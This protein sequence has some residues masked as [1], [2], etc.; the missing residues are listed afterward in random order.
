MKIIQLAYAADFEGWRVSARDALLAGVEPGGIDWATDET[1]PSF[2][3]Q[4]DHGAEL[5]ANHIVDDLQD[6]GRTR[7]A[8]NNGS[9]P[10]AA[11]VPKAFIDLS[12]QLIAH[13]DSERF[14][15][16]YRL[17]WRLQHSSRLLQNAADTDVFKAAK[18]AKH[19]RRDRHKMK[20]FVRFRK[21]GETADGIEQFVSWFE[22]THN[23]V[24]ITAPFFAK[25]FANMLWSI[26]TP[27]ACA[28]WD[29]KEL[30]FTSGITSEAAPVTDDLED[31]WRTY[32]ASIFNP[33][34]LKVAAMKS[35]MPKKYW[36]N[37]PEADL[38]PE[39][40]K[41]ARSREAAMIQSAPTEPN[42]TMMRQLHRSMPR[43]RQP[44]DDISDLNELGAALNR[45]RKCAFASRSTQ[46]VCGEGPARADMMIVG[47]QPGDHEDLT[48]HSFVGPAGVLL[49]ELLGEAQLNRKA[50]Y[51]T[52]AVK[53][54]KYEARGK[55]R[56]HIN[57]S[58]AEIDHCRWW[59]MKE[60]ELV[61]P[62]VIV[63]L[64]ASALTSIC[65][66]KIRLAECRGDAIFLG[67]D[68]RLVASFHPSYVLRQSGAEAMAARRAIVTDLKL[69]AGLLH[70]RDTA[71]ERHRMAKQKVLV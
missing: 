1:A 62:R 70:E 36:H 55:R 3:D 30:S 28:H 45:C 46:A 69:A 16:A 4:L 18:W 7:R 15:L 24:R 29:G 8:L 12:Q 26:L 11:S 17:L 56:L 19:V 37:L 66:R 67:R 58:A 6:A 14:A 65:G 59:L 27:E 63:S 47:E 68:R 34:R 60:I 39:L 48:G 42:P 23:I 49:D 10:G 51:V 41:A 32:Y 71:C 21:I 33:A 64:G 9:G 54:F 20:A 57:P 52:N 38:I 31:Y 2:L 53:H 22:P 44:L 13:S 50:L 5:E 35:E 61:Q 25:R 40:V 43:T